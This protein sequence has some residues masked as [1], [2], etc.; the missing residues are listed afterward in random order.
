MKFVSFFLAIN[1]LFIP[2]VAQAQQGNDASRQ[3]DNLIAKA[4]LTLALK[5]LTALQNMKRN[6]VDMEEIAAKYPKNTDMQGRAKNM[7]DQFSQSA[8]NVIEMIKKDLVATPNDPTLERYL[9]DCYYTTSRY[10][11]AIIEYSQAF[12]DKCRDPELFDNIT[13]CYVFLKQP[14]LV[15]TWLKTIIQQLGGTPILHYNLSIANAAIGDGAGAQREMDLV[16]KDDPKRA[17]RLKTMLEILK[18]GSPLVVIPAPDKNKLLEE[19]RSAVT[20]NPTSAAAQLQLGK[21]LIN[22]QRF[23]ESLVPLLT[24]VKLDPNLA[25]SHV[26]LGFSY[27]NLN[28]PASAVPELKEADRLSPR[29]PDVSF[30]L[31]TAL[32]MQSASVTGKERTD[33]LD[34]A[35]RYLVI[36]E[37]AKPG[38][39]AYNLACIYALQGNESA[40]KEALLTAKKYNTLPAR[41]AIEKD[42]DLESVRDKPWFKELI[43]ETN[44]SEKP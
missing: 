39:S 20:A 19:A 9:G 22:L 21:A 10:N 42:S 15:Q 28:R 4:Q 31:G 25:D 30:H 18:P 16:T 32:V 3:A 29:D 26:N 2:L 6:V 44:K 1:L 33:M 37:S 35:K 34:E 23:Q 27:I 8:T 14:S 40:C 36:S 17:E 7:R 11:D 43:Q 12:T 13:L 41:E 38:R 5:A 24:A